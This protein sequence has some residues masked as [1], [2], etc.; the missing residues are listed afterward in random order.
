MQLNKGQD[1]RSFSERRRQEG[2]PWFIFDDDFRAEQLG[3]WATVPRPAIIH[4]FYFPVGWCLSLHSCS[5][6]YRED[7]EDCEEDIG[8]SVGG[9]CMDKTRQ[10]VTLPVDVVIWPNCR[11]HTSHKVL[12]GA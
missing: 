7:C 1:N 12:S 10:D 4:S 5:I 3:I 11:G 2:I 8:G 6:I 9:V